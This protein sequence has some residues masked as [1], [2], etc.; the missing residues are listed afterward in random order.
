MGW[1]RRHDDKRPFP[2]RQPRDSIP[3]D[4]FKALDAQEQARKQVVFNRKLPPSDIENLTQDDLDDMIKVN[5]QLVVSRNEP[6]DVNH[7]R[8]QMV[9]DKFHENDSIADAKDRIIKK[10]TALLAGISYHQPFSEGNKE[11]ALL[12]TTAFLNDNGFDI[13]IENAIVRSELIELLIKTIYKFE[14]DPTIFSEVEDYIKSRITEQNRQ[15]P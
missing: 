8:L 1:K 9:Y 7:D 5:K 6:F 11:V 3:L 12:K 4:V 14:N 15:E 10:A 2:E 13:P